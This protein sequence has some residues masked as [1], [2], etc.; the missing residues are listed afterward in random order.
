MTALT[1]GPNSSGRLPAS[2]MITMLPREWPMSTI[3]PS[4]A[5]IWST[6]Y[7]SSRSRSMLS[8]P[9]APAP[10]MPWPRTSQKTRR[11]DE[12]ASSARW[13]RQPVRLW[14]QPW[15]KTT[16][17]GASS[18]PSTSR[19]NVTPSKMGTF[20]TAP[21]GLRQ[22]NGLAEAAPVV[23]HDLRTGD[24]RRCEKKARILAPHPAAPPCLLIACPSTV[25]RLRERRCLS[26]CGSPPYPEFATLSRILLWPARLRSMKTGAMSGWLSARVCST[27]LKQHQG[28][29]GRPAPAG[30]RPVVRRSAT[31][32]RYCPTRV[33][34]H[35]APV[36]R[37]SVQSVKR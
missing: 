36:V 16:V 21:A 25:R 10:D 5:T 37:S 17:S 13:S 29:G 14:V 33:R 19:C 20:R 22:R 9:G 30:P 11:A 15:T 27:E 31:G 2:A 26:A 1:R 28:L 3:G 7:R 34:C 23:A 12:S 4:G 24:R 18:G 6:S 32:R 8:V 35:H